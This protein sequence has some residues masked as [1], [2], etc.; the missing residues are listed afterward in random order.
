MRWVSSLSYDQLTL[1]QAHS[2]RKVQT[3]AEAF[4]AHAVA[5]R[6]TFGSAY[7]YRVGVRVLSEVDELLLARKAFQ[8]VAIVLYLVSGMG[9]PQHEEEKDL[10]KEVLHFKYNAE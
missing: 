9:Q 2:L 10:R 4:A 1:Y 6:G 8:L 7:R 3:S 5:G